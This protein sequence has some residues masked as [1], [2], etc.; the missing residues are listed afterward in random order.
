MGRGGGEDIDRI[1]G[2]AGLTARQVHPGSAGVAIVGAVDAAARQECE[3]TADGQHVAVAVVAVHAACFHGTALALGDAAGMALVTGVLDR[4]TR[5]KYGQAVFLEF[6]VELVHH[7][8]N[9]WLAY[10]LTSRSGT[11]QVQCR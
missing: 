9:V 7:V 4:I 2:V 11:G 10:L 5:W 6:P 8:G 3:C 1:P